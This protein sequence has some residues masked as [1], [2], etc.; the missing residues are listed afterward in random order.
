MARKRRRAPT[1]LPRR[2]IGTIIRNP[3]LVEDR[4]ERI[5]KAAIRVFIRHGYD[6]APVREIAEEAGLSPGGLY[7]YI[8][9]KEDIL[10]LVFEKLTAARYDSI[11]TAIAHKRGPVERIEAATRAH[12][13]TVRQFQDEVLLMYHESESLNPE[14]LATVLQ[15]EAD[16]VKYF[17]G[18]LRP[19]YDSGRFKGNPPLAANIVVFLCAM[20]ALRRWNLRRQFSDEEVIDG[21]VDFILRGLGTDGLAQDPPRARETEPR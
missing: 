21:V 6:R 12:L 16:Y 10:Y 3:E 1:P 11:Q 18:I 5:F 8:K 19:G 2:P 7:T 14:S 13:E 9:T 17:E 4:R 15:R 20:L